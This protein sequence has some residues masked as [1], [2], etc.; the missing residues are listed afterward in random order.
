MLRMHYALWP[1]LRVLSETPLSCL[2]WES[3][4]SRSIAWPIGHG[5]T[6]SHLLITDYFLHY[7]APVK[8]CARRKEAERGGKKGLTWADLRL[9]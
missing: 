7:D 5:A 1:A 2:F 9:L 8:I 6:A 3:G 4:T